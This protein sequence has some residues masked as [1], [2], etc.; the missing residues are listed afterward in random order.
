MTSKEVT[1][2]KGFKGYVDEVRLWNKSLSRTEIN[3]TFNRLL[4][5]N[6]SSLAAYWRFDDG[7]ED[8]FYDISNYASIYNAR[9]GKIHEATISSEIPEQGQL[10]LVGITGTDGVYTIT[11]I[12]YNGDGSSYTLTPSYP[13]HTFNPT[14]TPVTIGSTATALSDINFTDNSAIMI[15]GFVFYENSTIPVVGATFKINGQTVFDGNGTLITSGSDG[16]FKFSVPTR[17]AEGRGHQ[18]KPY[19][20]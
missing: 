16:K 15:D 14:S 9:H 1:I 13:N 10:A 19:L 18:A 17:T 6:E 5:G 3:Q 20:C 4:V 8:E 2:G 7:L 11:G 12:P